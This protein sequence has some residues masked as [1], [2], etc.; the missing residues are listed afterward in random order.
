MVKVD[1]VYSNYLNAPDGASRFVKTMKAQE[2]LFAE[3]GI[4][5]RVITPDLFSHRDFCEGN[6][7]RP[8]FFKKI[9]RKISKY[10]ILVTMMRIYRSYT[11]PIKRILDYYEQIDNKGS[12]IA[13]QESFTAYY[14]LK[15]KKKD[16]QKV[17]LTLH[18]NG[19]IWT[20]MAQS[21]PKI[22]SLLL[23][24]YRDDFEKTLFSGCDKIGFVADAP[25]RHFCDIYH[26]PEDQT[27]FCYNGVAS[28]PCPIRECS[29]TLDLVCVG[30]VNKRKNQIGVL[31]AISLLP[32][33]YQ[34]RITFRIVGDG[35]GMFLLKQKAEG[36]KTEI[37]F[38]GNSNEV[39]KH[40]QKSNCFV[41]FSKDEGLPISIIEGMRSGLPIIGTNIAGVPEQI[42]DGINGFLV[43]VNEQELAEK[44]RYLLDHLDVLSDM[45]KVSYSIFL[46]KFTLEAMVKKYAEI[47]K[48]N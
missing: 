26:F 33:D 40:L 22:K 2:E 4:E 27:Y 12:V 36:L 9:V 14:F 34:K 28:K 41:L 44:L 43:D 29:I 13:F 7:A 30:S 17:L 37:I 32:A 48:E 39:D 1:L 46:K 20:M 42:Q 16:S 10:S 5:L 47:Y 24:G 25:R 38:V 11:Q 3:N 18:N 8:S 23:K 35:T 15:R 45:G 31:D 19:E 6:I 21:L